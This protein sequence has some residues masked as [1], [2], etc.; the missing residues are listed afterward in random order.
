MNRANQ[1]ETNDR[2]RSQCRTQLE[3]L[4]TTVQMLEAKIRDYQKQNRDVKHFERNLAVAKESVAGLEKLFNENL[5]GFEAR[6]TDVQ[7]EIQRLTCASDR[8]F[9]NGVST[10][11]E[12]RSEGG[13]ITFK[14]NGSP[15][16]A[17][18]VLATADATF[19][20]QNGRAV[21]GNPDRV[22]LK[23]FAEG[24]LEFYVCDAQDPGNVEKRQK[25]T[26]E[27]ALELALF[28]ENPA[29]NNRRLQYQEPV[30]RE[31][32]AGTE[33]KPESTKPVESKA[34]VERAS[35]IKEAQAELTKAREAL[36]VAEQ[37]SPGSTEVSKALQQVE[38]WSAKLALLQNGASVLERRG[39]RVG[40]VNPLNIDSLR[41]KTTGFK[42]ITG[43][44]TFTVGKDSVT[45]T[46]AREGW[47]VNVDSLG[48]VMQAE[49]RIDPRVNWQYQ[50]D[51]VNQ[52]LQNA[53]ND[54]KAGRFTEVKPGEG[55]REAKPAPHEK[56]NAVERPIGE[57]VKEAAR[58]FS[59][60]TDAN[61]FTYTFSS[62]GSVSI[63]GP[64]N[65]FRLSINAIGDVRLDSGR[66][67]EGY[68]EKMRLSLKQMNREGVT[69]T[70]LQMDGFR[71]ATE[72]ARDV[73]PAPRPEPVRS[74]GG[75][76]A[77]AN[78]YERSGS[79]ADPRRSSSEINRG[80]ATAEE[81]QMDRETSKAP[82]RGFEKPQAPNRP[83]P[84]PENKPRAP[85]VRRIPGRP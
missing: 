65:S 67:P 37:K 84:L 30:A 61:K 14:E 39:T 77:S 28:G 11:L 12:G 52:I 57:M 54:M 42:D 63:T 74:S 4:K 56:T 55:A 43:D 66:P 73:R 58:R 7:R 82:E 41:S 31:R 47:S 3:S 9:V 40:Q 22:I 59:T 15:M 13:K 45:V 71:K 50:A 53:Q 62:D 51:R 38:M 29:V 75:F 1:R 44:L 72:R 8:A 60:V 2:L 78:P 32:S 48:N 70:E 25:V 76:R 6:V 23:V 49:G 80:N 27:K 21:R 69:P 68:G 34:D 16:S 17:E 79:G 18:K 81:K 83:T 24:V 64:D 46:N 36:S 35:Q 5:S 85:E 10:V 33:A 19:S 20:R 26:A